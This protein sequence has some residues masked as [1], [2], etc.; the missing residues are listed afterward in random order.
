MGENIKNQYPKLNS[1]GYICTSCLNSY[2]RDHIIN[3]SQSEKDVLTDL[4]QDVINISKD[5]KMLVTEI[6]NKIDKKSTILDKVS[7][8]AAKFGGSW[9]FILIFSAVLIVWITINLVSVINR[10]FDPFSFAL[11]NLVLSCLAAFQAP[12]IMLSQNRQEAKDRKRGENEY[13]INTKAEIGV[14][15]QVMWKI[16]KGQKSV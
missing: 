6:Y 4:D 9:S 7:D 14:S 3:S 16:V 1:S 11:L 10:P 12:I 2:S 5:E 15:K 8:K 13:Q